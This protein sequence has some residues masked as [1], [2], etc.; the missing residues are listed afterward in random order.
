[1]YTRE[2]NGK[3]LELRVSGKL[4]KDALVMLDRETGTLWTQVDGKALRGPLLGSRLSEIPAVQTTWKAWKKLYPD[5]L[6]LRKPGPLSGSNYS[7]YFRDPSKRG[8]FGTRGDERLAGKDK[9]VGVHEGTDA[10]AI[11]ESLLQKKAVVQ[12]RLADKPVVV[13][14]APEA[15]TP[16]VYRPVVEGKTLS[17]RVR[18]VGGQTQ[19]EDVG[20]GSVWSALEGKAVN[21]PLAGKHLERVPYLHSFWYAW[22]AYRPETRIVSE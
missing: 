21:G 16:G 15:E 3:E 4:Y 14:Y 19:I 20:T 9:I 12:F 5:T 13:M 1:M 8:L 7:A 11:P 17:F 10:V 22:S 2:V 18:Q 6:V